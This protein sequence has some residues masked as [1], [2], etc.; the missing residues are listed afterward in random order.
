MP[1]KLPPGAWDTHTHT[2]N[3]IDFPLKSDRAYTP[4]SAP[5]EKLLESCAANNIVLVQTTVE[6]GFAGLVANLRRCHSTAMSRNLRGIILAD[7]ALDTLTDQEYDH[8]HHIGVRAIRL[9]GFHGGSGD[10]ISWVRSQILRLASSYPV[11]V[12]SWK[13]SA[14]LPLSS[15]AA[16]KGFWSE[17][18]CLQ[19]V[20][21]IADHFGSAVPAD[22][23]SASL[24]TFVEMIQ[25]GTLHVKLSALHRRSPQNSSLMEPVVKLFASRASHALLWGSDWPH[26]DASHT[27]IDDAGSLLEVDT[28]E[29]LALLRTWLSQQQWRDMLVTNPQRIFGD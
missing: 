13:L 18:Q 3:P 17:H 25:N 9:H 24:D 15:W 11:K 5:F 23:G 20:T 1:P 28:Y 19:H 10:S 12:Y 21:M 4:A 7:P 22:L 6:D 26:V 2:F 14:Q 27:A 29:E 16:L 8:L